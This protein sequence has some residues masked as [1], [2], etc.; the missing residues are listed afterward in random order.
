[1]CYKHAKTLNCRFTYFKMVHS[2]ITCTIIYLFHDI[3]IQKYFHPIKGRT[4]G[5]EGFF[6]KNTN[7]GKYTVI[8]G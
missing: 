6:C 8:L 1:M 7:L 3:L 5:D 2:A 4:F